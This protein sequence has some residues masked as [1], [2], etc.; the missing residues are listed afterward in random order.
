MK[1]SFTLAIMAASLSLAACTTTGLDSSSRFKCS[2]DNTAG[3][4]SISQTFSSSISG[5]KNGMANDAAQVNNALRKTPYSGMPVRTPVS[6]LRIWVAPWE[7]LDHDLRDQSFMYVALNES[8]WQIAHNQESIINEYRPT[9]RLLG[10]GVDGSKPSTKL[11]SDSDMPDLG[12][13]PPVDKSI[14][15]TLDPL[16][17]APNL[18]PPPIK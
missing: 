11:A 14:D 12:I 16:S 10:G 6:V 9:I 8:K 15:K 2:Y 5:Q 1:H 18:V 13:V 7:D 17:L 3:C 4:E